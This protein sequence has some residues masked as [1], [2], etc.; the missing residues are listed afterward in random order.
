MRRLL[1]LFGSS[2]N[3]FYLSTCICFSRAE[4]AVAHPTSAARMDPFCWGKQRAWREKLYPAV[5]HDVL[6][7]ITTED[8][9]VS[10]SWF[11]SS[12]IHGLKAALGTADR[13]YQIFFR[14]IALATITLQGS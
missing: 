11:N 13:S 10:K 2:K 12:S 3:F 4:Q 8:G 5:L 9:A 7:H 14:C 6:D 1:S